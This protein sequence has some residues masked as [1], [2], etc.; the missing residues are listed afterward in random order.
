M[1]SPV[2]VRVQKRCDA[3][4]KAGLRPMQIWVPDTGRP[5]FID[6]CRRQMLAVADNADMD[7]Q[8]F[9]DDVLAEVDGWTD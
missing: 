8:R 6:G 3:L 1:A 4:H 9:I 2:D 7:M 5:G